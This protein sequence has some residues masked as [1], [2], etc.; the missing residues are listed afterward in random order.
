MA[1]YGFP[2]TV[3]TRAEQFTEPLGTANRLITSPWT[4]TLAAGTSGLRSYDIIDFW[5][6]FDERIDHAD[7]PDRS[8]YEQPALSPAALPELFVFLT[9]SRHR[10]G[11]CYN[12]KFVCHRHRR[13]FISF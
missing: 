3:E 6:W 4:A 10:G 7:R 11:R 13:K 8:R 12:R 9:A 1:R 5:T 2:G